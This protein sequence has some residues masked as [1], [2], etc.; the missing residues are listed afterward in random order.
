MHKTMKF[1]DFMKR[2]FI[3]YTVALVLIMFLLFITFMILN[4]RIFIIKAN[5]DCNQSVS[6]FISSHYTI[7][8]DGLKEFSKNDEIK[9][10]LLGKGDL[11]EVN[12]LLYEFSLAQPIKGNFVL[13]KNDGSI[14]STNLYKTNQM[15]F[16]A[17]SAVKDA[18][19]RLDSDADM[20]YSM[21][22]RIPY[23]NGQPSNIIITRAVCSDDKDILGYL[24]FGLKEE[25]ISAFMR[26]MAADIIVITD[27]FNNVIFSTNSLIID[28]M[29]KYKAEREDDTTAIID[30]KPYYVTTGTLLEGGL[31]VITMTSV[32]KQQQ[33]L[34]FGFFFL[35]GM[36]CFLIV[37]VQVLADKVT[38]GNLRSIDELLYAV[39]ECRNGNIDYRIKFQTFSEF[40]IL[41][42]EFNNMMVK[43]QKLIKNNNE[44]AE[45]KRWMEVKHL[46]GQFNPHFVFNVLET[47]R[48]EIMIDPA[49]ASRMVVSFANLMR[50]SI[51]YGSTHVPLKTD[52]GYVQDYL[53][54]QKMRYNQRLV[55]NI[56]IEENL[57]ECKIPKLLIQP[58]VENSVVHGM[59]NTR[60]LTIH[61]VGRSFGNYFTISVEDDGPGMRTE[62]LVKLRA[63]LDDENAMPQRIG[64]YNVHRAAQLLYGKEYGL[65]ID[66]IEGQGMKAVLKIPIILEADD[67]V[68][69]ANC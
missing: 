58:I 5:K 23:D 35:I 41:Y 45:R 48:Y 31:K 25:S 9:K 11:K 59:E 68:Q 24:F 63:L 1:K 60:K 49:Q 46:E 53:L 27:R 2:M 33:L 36:S 66:S 8:T 67:D 57:L 17:N 15:L 47:L 55:Y 62:Q 14:I 6:D 29:G 65:T 7:Y 61:I 40:Q 44:L 56:D 4:Y 38:S 18:I 50:Y 42:D 32:A 26:N 30:Q 43:I 21:A 54:L 34:Q 28:S 37:L 22:V 12:R 51:N 69:G 20:T 19:N 64:L 3:R 52:I 16:L 39:S 10:A 13:L